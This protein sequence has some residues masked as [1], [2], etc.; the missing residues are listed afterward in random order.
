MPKI[1]AT[2]KQ[3]FILHCHKS[4][5]QK[6]SSLVYFDLCLSESY[7]ELHNET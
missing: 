5:L 3:H 4:T 1:P 7:P 6:Y 2:E